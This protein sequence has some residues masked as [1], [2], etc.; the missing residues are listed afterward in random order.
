[1]H[2]RPI[3][4]MILVT[5]RADVFMNSIDSR[6]HMAEGGE[7]MLH[8]WFRTMMHIIYA[9]RK[10]DPEIRLKMLVRFCRIF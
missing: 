2:R 5:Q 10:L 6:D 3:L 4:N 9:V 7:K 1:M 8:T